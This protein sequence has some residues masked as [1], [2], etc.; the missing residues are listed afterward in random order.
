VAGTAW[1]PIVVDANGIIPLDPSVSPIDIP[2]V[3]SSVSPNSDLNP[4]GGT[5]LT[6]T[7]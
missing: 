1:L 3:V 6:I 4:Y 7:G 5:F 2:L